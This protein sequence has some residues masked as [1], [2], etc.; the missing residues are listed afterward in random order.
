MLHVMWYIKS[1]NNPIMF[2]FS[3]SHQAYSTYPVL[4]GEALSPDITFSAL[5]IFNQ[6]AFPLTILPQV[7]TFQI[8]GY[9]ST[10]RLRAFF[11]APEI[12]ERDDGRQK[13][14]WGCSAKKKGAAHNVDINGSVVSI[15]RQMQHRYDISQ[16]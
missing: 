15:C 1:F 5:T 3:I 16:A 11:A 9:I 8:N 7:F 4:S 10:R 6:L 14:E 2:F 13:E 12:E